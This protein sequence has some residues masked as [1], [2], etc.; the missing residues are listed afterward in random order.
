MKVLLVN[1]SPHENGSTYTALTAAAEALKDGGIGTEFFWIGNKPV[2]GCIACRTCAKTGKCFVDDVVND[3]RKLAAEADGFVFGTP[4]YY[5]SAAGSMVS[6]MDR[7]FFSES[8]GNG[9]N[10]F[11]LKP[12]ATVVVARR[13]G[14]TSTFEQINKYLTISQMPVVSSCYWNMA[15]GNSPDEIRQDTEG[16]QIMRVLGRNIAYLLN[17]LEAG[18]KVGVKPP[19]NEMR[20]YTNFIR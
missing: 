20:I 13:G 14:T 19:E 16:M 15:H 10:A 18:R 12:A 4:V 6:F 1:G 3:F 17:C 11:R 9:G 8:L 2:P 7:V 5:A